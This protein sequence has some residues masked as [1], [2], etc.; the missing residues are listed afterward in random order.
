M[1]M[2][3]NDHR[4]MMNNTQPTQTEIIVGGT[5]LED[6]FGQLS[7]YLQQVGRLKK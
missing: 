7:I 1:T 2:R 3:D 6:E 5:P 4:I